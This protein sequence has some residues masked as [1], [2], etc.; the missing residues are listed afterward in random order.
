MLDDRGEVV[1]PGGFTNAGRV[2]RVGDTVRR[3]RR[4]TSPRRG[5]CSMTLSASASTARRAFPGSAVWDVTCAARLWAPLR[6][7]R[8]APEGLRGR[9]LDRLRIFV[10]AYGLPRRDR[11]RVVDA[12]IH[13]HE[14]CY[15]VV[16]TAVGGGHET[17]GR[18]WRQ[19]GQARAD[20]TPRWIASHGPQMRRVGGSVAKRISG[21]ATDAVS[22]RRGAL[23]AQPWSRAWWE[24]LIWPPAVPRPC[25]RP[26]DAG[27]SGKAQSGRAAGR[28][29]RR[30]SRQRGRHSSH[31]LSDRG[32]HRILAPWQGRA[33]PLRAT[34]ERLAPRPSDDRI[35]RGS[36]V[37]IR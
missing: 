9:T 30:M 15:R 35:G 17:F 14:Q 2:T 20:R 24:Q 19:G 37:S 10:D 11:S 28:R 6:E 34:S 16:R 5:P 12:A 32:H 8:D 23:P 21:P 33:L 31:L 29:P 4:P 18:M 27:W 7:E 26:Q 1:L 13:T 36:G 25:R 3:P 22:V